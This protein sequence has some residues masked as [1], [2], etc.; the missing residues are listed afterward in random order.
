MGC[1]YGIGQKWADE[2]FLASGGV[3]RPVTGRRLCFS[4]TKKRCRQTCYAEGINLRMH[5]QLRSVGALGRLAFWL[6][7][8]DRAA[9][10]DREVFPWPHANRSR[11]QETS[12]P[13]MAWR[14][15]KR[16]GGTVCSGLETCTIAA[17]AIPTAKNARGDQVRNGPAAGPLPA[18]C[19][20]RHGP[21]SNSNGFVSC[22]AGNHGL[23]PV[24]FEPLCS[25][26]AADERFS[27]TIQ[28]LVQRI[29]RPSQV[30]L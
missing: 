6:R 24:A 17:T 15:E 16:T 3:A 29:H 27:N 30:L 23:A 4:I 7:C 25:L 14:E 18:Q 22:C 21:P 10:V 26:D 20:R 5:R 1:R 28:R 8:V 11:K 13:S 2:T 9:V 19:C 12:E